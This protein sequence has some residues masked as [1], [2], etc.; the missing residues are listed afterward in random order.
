[1]LFSSVIQIICIGPHHLVQ[2]GHHYI[3]FVVGNDNTAVNDLDCAAPQLLMKRKNMK[4]I[5]SSI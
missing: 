3:G 5:F 2:R 1:M 4:Y